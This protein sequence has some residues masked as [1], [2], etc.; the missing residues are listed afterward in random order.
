MVTVALLVAVPFLFPDFDRSELLPEWNSSTPLWLGA[1][2]ALTI[3]S[4]WFATLRWHRVLFAFDVTARPR[5]LFVHFLAGQ[6]ASQFMPT[7]IGGDVIRV[8]RLRRDSGNAP[9]AFASVVFERLSGWIVLPVLTF[10]GFIVNP[11]L[12]DLGAATRVAFILATVTLVGL[13]TLMAVVGNPVLGRFLD[14]RDGWARYVNAL[15]LGIDKFR[16]H[17][18]ELVRVLATAF[19]YQII[20]LLAAACAAEA[21]GIGQVGLTAILAFMPVT[22]IAQFMSPGFGGFGFREASLALFLGK[23]GVPEERAIALGLVIY[24][25]TVTSSL[26]GVPALVFG[27]SKDNEDES[28]DEPRESLETSIEP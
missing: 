27:G 3:T 20:L 22:L 21:M 5:R 16:E 12:R 6:V 2:V 23:L 18:R 8:N 28:V 15:H 1:A 14:K 11:G 7:S 24:L 4:Y 19:V 13:L 10:A 26:I 17:P 25:I 9:G